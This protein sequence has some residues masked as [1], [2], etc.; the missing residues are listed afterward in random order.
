[1]GIWLEVSAQVMALRLRS[2]RNDASDAT[3]EVLQQQ[4]RHNPG[5]IDWLRIDAG[6]DLERSFDEVRR[7]VASASTVSG[8]FGSPGA[9][10]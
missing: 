9:N 8:G 3:P 10:G 6:Q 1:M 2:R 5:P 4:L 7:A